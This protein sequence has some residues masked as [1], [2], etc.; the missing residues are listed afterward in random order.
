MKNS[1]KVEAV[2]SVSSC[3]RSKYIF[4][5]FGSSLHPFCLGRTG[6][7][8]FS[9][10]PSGLSDLSSCYSR[11]GGLLFF[12]VHGWTSWSSTISFW[13]SN[14]LSST[15]TT[16]NPFSMKNSRPLKAIFDFNTSVICLKISA[17]LRLKSSSNCITLMFFSQTTFTSQVNPDFNKFRGRS[18]VAESRVAITWAEIVSSLWSLRLCDRM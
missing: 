17:K 3:R 8:I 4:F 13:D 9:S 11:A 12:S 1:E 16:F 15:S 14:Q 18:K 5:W 6:I 2:L 10:V 7:S